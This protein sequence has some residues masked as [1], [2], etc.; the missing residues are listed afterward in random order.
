MTLEHRLRGP[1]APWQSAGRTYTII[2][3]AAANAALA[4]QSGA[5]PARPVDETRLRMV[6]GLRLLAG[7]WD[8]TAPPAQALRCMESLGMRATLL[9][10]PDGTSLHHEG[11]RPVRDARGGYDIALA[12]RTPATRAALL[13]RV[14]VA[15]QALR[16][17]GTLALATTVTVAGEELHWAPTSGPS[18]VGD[19]AESAISLATVRGI[20]TAEGFIAR[21]FGWQAAPSFAELAPVGRALSAPR[22]LLVI[23]ALGDDA[24]ARRIGLRS[25]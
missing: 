14:R 18:L 2:T 4:A 12:L 1:Q 7:V 6:Q 15:R 17:A 21:V 22:R 13:H 19:D 25:A 11:Q 23:A 5:A 10:E 20:L 9:D 3:S 24:D 8:D 16:P